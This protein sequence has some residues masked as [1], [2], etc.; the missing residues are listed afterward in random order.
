MSLAALLGFL[1]IAE[2]STLSRSGLLGLG[3]GFL[4]LAIPCRHKLMT[5][6]SSPSAPSPEC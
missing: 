4:L 6:F 1:L 3:I 5:K 2:L